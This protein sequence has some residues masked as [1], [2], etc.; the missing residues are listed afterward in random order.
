M[1]SSKP[2]FISKNINK[3]LV[4]LFV[5][6][7][8]LSL[9]FTSLV[10]LV[11]FQNISSKQSQAASVY[12]CATGETL[13]GTNCTSTPTTSPIY[14]EACPSGY[15]AMD[16]VCVTF[17]Q[18]VCTDYPEAVVDT[19]DAAMCKIENINNVQLSEVTDSDGRQ[20]KGVGYNFK[21]YNV[22]F[23]LTAPNG[24]IVCAS[25][26][27][28]VFGKENFRFV[29]KTIT[30]IKNFETTQTGTS[31]PICPTGYTLSGAVCTVPAIVSNCSVAGEFLIF[32]NTTCQTCPANSYCL[33]TTT[34]ETTSGVCPNGGTLAGNLCIA[35]NQVSKT[36]Y[37]DGCTSTYVRY[38]KTCA[39]EE[40]RTHDL[41]CSYFYASDNVNVLAV[42]D[43]TLPT[44]TLN[45][46][47]TGGRTDFST[48]SITKVSDLECAGPG[49]GWYNYNVAYDPLVCG[50]TFDPNNKAAFRW[51]EKTFTKIVG[52]QKLG[53]TITACPANW[54]F[55]AN[56]T[57][58]SQA[59][60]SRKF[61]V[62]NACPAA[63]PNSPAGST[64]LSNCTATQTTV[65]Q[66]TTPGPAITINNL[67]A[68]SGYVYVDTNN[69]GV[70]DSGEVGIS[71]V[72]IK[73]LG[74]SESCKSVAKTTVTDVGGKYEF[75]DFGA[76]IYSVIETQPVN[77]IDGK[78]TV[79]KINE[80]ITGQTT[81]NDK[82]TSIT[83]LSGQ[84]SVYNN[85]GELAK[86]TLKTNEYIESNECKPCPKGTYTQVA[87]AKSVN[88]CKENITIV[89]PDRPTIRTGGL[90]L[91]ELIVL[92]FAFAVGLLA[93]YVI[94][95]NRREFLEGWFKAK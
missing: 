86:C 80:V 84:N 41:G 45:V 10:G 64:Q 32:T 91:L 24:P 25:A 1:N 48:Y 27:S 35:A 85:F 89:T 81:Q 44:N 46:C 13:S 12:I 11:G 42:L 17:T 7:G 56:S 65:T 36:T 4:S 29:P 40:I 14:T 70:V 74:E 39:I 5:V 2:S 22:G 55:V 50:N 69:N 78:E 54:T 38:D 18:K 34:G 93:L 88:D 66:T 94:K 31:T 15:A 67:S 16:Y 8:I 26:F 37:I 21:Q 53:T 52:L 49:T 19:V 43:T 3:I 60:I 92:I 72:E 87:D 68:I 83:I 51:S 79:G 30:S 90:N 57:N 63:T 59:P 75:K 71:G 47:S 76:C 9:V 73:L 95:I 58:C 33:N 82:I 62:V 23:P 28:A 77:Y 6:T 20:C 61:A